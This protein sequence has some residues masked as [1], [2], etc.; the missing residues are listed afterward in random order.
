MTSLD[1]KRVVITHGHQ[2]HDGNVYD[3]VKACGAELWAHELYFYFL[4][5]SYHDGRLS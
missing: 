5:Y 4:P 1:L 2:D 3:L